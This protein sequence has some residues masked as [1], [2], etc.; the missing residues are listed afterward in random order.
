[1]NG[2]HMDCLFHDPFDKHDKKKIT[3][4][5]FICVIDG[6]SPAESKCKQ[7]GFSQTLIRA[8]KD[9]EEAR[10]GAEALVDTSEAE[11]IRRLSYV[12]ISRTPGTSLSVLEPNTTNTGV[13]SSH[14]TKKKRKNSWKTPLPCLPDL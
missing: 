12:S 2:R 10:Q 1:M 3:L 4:S 8:L 14:S 6:Y 5:D 13:G 11:A 7:Y 9:L